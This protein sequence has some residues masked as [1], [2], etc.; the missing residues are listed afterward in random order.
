MS[1]TSKNTHCS[2]LAIC[3]YLKTSRKRCSFRGTWLTNAF[4]D[5]GSAFQKRLTLFL[6]KHKTM[7]SHYHSSAKYTVRF[8]LLE[9]LERNTSYTDAPRA[10][11]DSSS[12]I[13]IWK[14]SNQ[15]HLGGGIKG[16]NFS[17]QDTLLNLLSPRTGSCRSLVWEGGCQKLKKKK[18]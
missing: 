6:K 13:I 2:G 17:D 3:S 8:K 10:L 18:K 11:G 14:L 5:E 12:L 9:L 4:T 15:P 7:G 16:C 1:V